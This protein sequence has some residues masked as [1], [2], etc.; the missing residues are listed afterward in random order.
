MA[1][2]HRAGDEPSDE[3]SRTARNR[4]PGP[5]HETPGRP[6]RKPAYKRVPVEVVDRPRTGVPARSS[7]ASARARPERPA[8]PQGM[9]AAPARRRADGGG[10]AGILSDEARAYANRAAMR[11]SGGKPSVVGRAG[12]GAAAGAA[13]GAALGSVVPGIGTAVG[14]GT[15]AA[16]GGVG[17]GISGARAK[18]A[19]KA[20]MRG[21]AGARRI[22]IAEF[23]VCIVIAA[24]SP[25]TDRSRDEPAGAW[26]KRMTAIMGLF[27]ILALLSAGGRGMARAAAGFGGIV[28][29]VL[30]VSERD[31]FVKIAQIFRT[32]D[33]AADE[34][35]GELAEP[36]PLHATYKAST[37]ERWAT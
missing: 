26:M 20:S 2:R 18:R 33:E 28:T 5:K 14:A 35:A 31:L 4:R 13:S 19:Y 23:A 11:A 6:P 34:P 10:R 29:V 21:D 17:G 37:S 24:L 32:K 22:I 15:G 8:P 16:V 9:P 30:A 7:V 36:A 27:F 12:A 25:L 3:R 1:P